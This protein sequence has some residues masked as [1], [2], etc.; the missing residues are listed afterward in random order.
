MGISQLCCWRLCCSQLCSNLERHED[1]AGDRGCGPIQ[2]DSVPCVPDGVR[3][4]CCRVPSFGRGQRCT[5]RQGLC[6]R[7]KSCSG[8]ADPQSRLYHGARPAKGPLTVFSAWQPALEMFLVP[9]RLHQ[10]LQ[11]D[12]SHS[13]LVPSTAPT[14]GGRGPPPTPQKLPSPTTIPSHPLC[15]RSPQPSPTA[16]RYSWCFAAARL[17]TE[18]EAVGLAQGHRACRPAPRLS[19]SGLG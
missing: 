6:V 4:C 15:L 12:Q 18:L 13:A 1:T 9:S 17:P 2:L 8:K 14:R 11:T 19:A 10:M 16:A 3:W 7:E 5:C